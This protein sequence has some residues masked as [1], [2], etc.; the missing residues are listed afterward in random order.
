MYKFINFE[1]VNKKTQFFKLR[2]QTISWSHFKAWLNI[3]FSFAAPPASVFI[4]YTKRT[5]AKNANTESPYIHRRGILHHKI[6]CFA[7]RTSRS[8]P[9]NINTAI[10]TRIIHS[11]KNIVRSILYNV[12]VFCMSHKSFHTQSAAVYGTFRSCGPCISHLEKRKISDY[13]NS[14]TVII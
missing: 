11:A 2:R 7:L 10:W 12:R 5:D 14:A 9:C 3:R 4:S 13:E 8:L 1:M 6:M